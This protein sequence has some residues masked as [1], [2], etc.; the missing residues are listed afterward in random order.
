MA[1]GRRGNPGKYSPTA[2]GHL[3]RPAGDREP[4]HRPPHRAL[5]RCSTNPGEEGVLWAPKGTSFSSSGFTDAAGSWDHNWNSTSLTSSPSLGRERSTQASLRAR[6]KRESEPSRRHP[7]PIEELH[8][9]HL[10]MRPVQ[11]HQNIRGR[12][13]HPGPIA[14]ALLRAHQPAATTCRSPPDP[15]PPHRSPRHRAPAGCPGPRGCL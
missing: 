3:H 5:G 11:L 10:P 2:D 4:H 14:L 7:V 9:Q 8:Q 6:R 12:P 1:C 13:L 15:S